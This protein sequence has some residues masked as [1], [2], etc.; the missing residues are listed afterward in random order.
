MSQPRR[1]LSSIM[2]SVAASRVDAEAVKAR[3]WQENG[4]LVIAEHDER[5]TDADQAD[6]RRL[7][8]KLYGERS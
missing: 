5:L 6:V 1:N 3:G 4:I 2:G 8:R 7:G